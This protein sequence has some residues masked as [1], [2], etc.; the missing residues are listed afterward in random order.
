M[1][2]F[3]AAATV[4]GVV[5][6][7]MQVAQAASTLITFLDTIIDAPESVVRIKSLLKAIQ[8]GSVRIRKVLKRQ[9][10]LYGDDG[11]AEEEI[12]DALSQCQKKVVKMQTVLNKF[13]DFQTENSKVS[14]SWARL[15]VALK[16]DDM[17]E[18]E[19]QLTQDLN[20]LHLLL[21]MNIM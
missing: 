17:V 12:C 13:G 14:R 4:V 21:E 7:A 3:S 18:I 20:A 1:D 16:K 19:R 2:P 6:V 15:K 9:H 10:A 5:G 11:T 8:L